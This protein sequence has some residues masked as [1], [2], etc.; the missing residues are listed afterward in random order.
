VRVLVTGG[1]GFIDSQLVARFVR[2]RRQV[3]VLHNFSTNAVRDCEAVAP[4][5]G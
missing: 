1:G 2:Q 5:V 3:R 4:E